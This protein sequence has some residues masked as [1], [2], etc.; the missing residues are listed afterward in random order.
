M[1]KRKQII[2]QFKQ[3]VLGIWLR[4]GQNTWP[5]EINTIAHLF[6]DLFFD[7]LLVDMTRLKAGGLDE[8]AIAARFRT[9]ARIFRLIMP[10]VQGMKAL[11]LPVD[12]IRDHVIYFF[13]LM[14]Y[15]KQGDP[16][17]RDG[18]NMVFSQ[19]AFEEAVDAS[20]MVPA[21]RK[22]SLPVHKLCAVL[23]NYAECVCFRAHG[24]IRE[25]HGP[26]R[27][28]KSQNKEEILLRDFICLKAVELWDQCRAVPYQSVRI[29]TAYEG[30][31]MTIDVYNNVSIKEG[32]S[33]IGSL[34][35][36]YVE[37]DGKILDLEEIDGLSTVLSD[38]M[39]SITTAVDV[40]DWRRLA[41]KYAEIFW[42]S[43]K[44]LRDTLDMDWRIPGTVKERIE[45]GELN[46]RLQGLGPGALKR[47]LQI[48]F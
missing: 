39:I 43:K 19:D 13:S 45:T 35:S 1:E 2:E 22:N 21:D 33:Y 12:K 31:D 38:V 14:K 29:V 36:Y 9:P 46:T 25:F 41:L 44:E 24:L 37:A 7:E 48:A 27:F 11:G 23:W 10:C 15:L 20:K 42:F 8:R 5:I 17:N 32:G 47:M 34:K 3:A 28:N 6:M 30:L 40:L 4:D 26:Y 16:F 18:K